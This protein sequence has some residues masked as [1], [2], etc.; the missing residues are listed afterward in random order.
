M[1]QNLLH[2]QHVQSKPRYRNDQHCC[3]QLGGPPEKVLRELAFVLK[4]TQRVR[5]QM[6]ADAQETREPL[7]V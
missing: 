7:A 5:E 2:E 6:D 1:T 4:M 3:T